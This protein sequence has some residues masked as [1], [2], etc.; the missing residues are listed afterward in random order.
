M[1]NS[2]DGIILATSLD[3]VLLLDRAM[4]EIKRVLR[5]KGYVF[6]WIGLI[7]ETK[8]YD[9][10]AEDVEAY[11]KYHM[12][13][14]SKKGLEILMQS[15]YNLIDWIQDIAHNHYYVFQLKEK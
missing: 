1:D 2:F 10:Y 5:P 11:D 6:I 15:D 13:H 12:F 3:H 8:D 14:M 4:E 7:N 9:P